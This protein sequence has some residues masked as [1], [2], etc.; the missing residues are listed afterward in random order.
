MKVALKG[1]PEHKMPVPEGIM[2]VRI[3]SETGLLAAGGGTNEYFKEGT[4]PTRY[5]S[6]SSDGNQ[7]YGGDNTNSEGP[8]STDDI[9]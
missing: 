2:T 9:F 5:A 4:E 1:V 6:P 7:V 8:V 3:D